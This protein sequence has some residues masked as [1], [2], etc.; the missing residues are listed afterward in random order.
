MTFST[1]F[2]ATTTIPRQNE[3]V[4][5]PQVSCKGAVFLT[6]FVTV[7]SVVLS[8]VFKGRKPEHFLGVHHCFGKNKRW[9]YLV[10]TS[11]KPGAYS[12]PC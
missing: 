11:L 5:K 3:K 2:P 10:S 1:V 9:D 12:L 8:V 7:L 6:D 4:L